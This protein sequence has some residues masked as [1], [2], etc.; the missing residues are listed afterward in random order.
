ME[1]IDINTISNYGQKY[2]VVIVGYREDPILFE[3]CLRSH[4]QNLFNTKVNKTYVIVDGMEREDRYMAGIFKKV[5]GNNGIVFLEDNH[6]N[7]KRFVCIL[8]EHKGKRHALYTGF[9]VSIINNIYGVICTDS[10]TEFDKNA[11]DS[12]IKV[13]ES[14][15][16]IGAVTGDMKISNPH[17]VIAVLSYIRYWFACNLERA[18]QSYNK[19]VLC[20]SGPIGIYKT[21]II[22]LFLE[23][24]ITQKFMG[25]ECTYGD[26]RHLTN[27]ILIKG[28]Q[29]LYTHLAWC[30]TDTPEEVTRFFDQQVRW[31]KSSYRELSWNVK[32][33]PHH[34]IWMCID[35]LYTAVYSFIVLSG[36]IYSLFAGFKI[37]CLY[38][39]I[40][41]LMNTLKSLYAV[42]LCDYN[43]FYMLY[44]IYGV[45]YILFL[46]PAKLYAGIT[47]SDIK[48]GTSDRIHR[49]NNY[50]NGHIF[51]STWILFIIIMFVVNLLDFNSTTHEEYILFGIIST[52]IS[53]LFLVSYIVSKC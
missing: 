53:S 29:V 35:L 11:I 18:Y 14:D 3:K 31:C 34:S 8:Q 40:L 5:Y 32:A 28:Y 42:I 26:D 16:S 24:F 22:K 38:L 50:N 44:G 4:L 20:V 9:N 51:A 45:V 37:L 17:S 48:W 10:D 7:D 12:L 1:L 25:K 15:D 33:I 27:N 39:F 41:V 49:N 13:I 36:F 21:S 30:R 52:Y 46:V 19:C 47:I 6:P 23:D 43:L 2:N